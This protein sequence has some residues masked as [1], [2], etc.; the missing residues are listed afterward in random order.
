MVITS[1]PSA[2]LPSYR[3]FILT[4]LSLLLISCSRDND[5]D[6]NGS[7]LPY[8]FQDG[9][10]TDNGNL[11]ELFATDG[12][13][14]SGIQQVNPS[15][16]QNLIMLSNTESTEGLSALMFESAPS[17]QVLSKIDIEKGGFIAPVGST[18]TIEADYYIESTGS[19]Q[20]LFLLDIECC[21]CWDPSVDDNQCPGI[22]LKLSGDQE[23]L[24]IERGKIL[25]S[26]I[27]QSSHSF[28][29]DEWVSVKWQ[30]ILF[31]D[32]TG[33]NKLYIN[34]EEVINENGKNM[35]NSTEF[36][37]AFAEN[38]IDFELSDPL[39]YE[40]FQIG[41]TANPTPSKVTMYI[42]NVRLSVE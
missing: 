14:W 31:P 28:P 10:E 42:D 13:R 27:N 37:Q 32:D 26:T 41:A 23:Y 17:D 5:Q 1:Y 12:N 21:S 11:S 16:D 29:R 24:S 7:N 35:P 34:D 40:R 6:E 15:N 3:L 36:K 39:Y 38:G 8:Y 4:L 25:G 9:F 18:L 2:V 22:R 33:L 30:M 20:D 19:I